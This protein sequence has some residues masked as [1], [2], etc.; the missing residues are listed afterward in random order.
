MRDT[1]ARARNRLKAEQAAARPSARATLG[2]L[3]YIYM[4]KGLDCM[5]DTFAHAYTCL[6]QMRTRRYGI[7]ELMMKLLFLPFPIIMYII[8]ILQCISL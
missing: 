4:Y 6:G 1:F 7:F 2:Y 5:Q 8:F 3:V